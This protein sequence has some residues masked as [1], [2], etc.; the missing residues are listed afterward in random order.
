MM[1]GSSAQIED[2]CPPFSGDLMAFNSNE[3][4]ARTDVTLLL[5]GD[6]QKAASQAACRNSLSLGHV[7][8]TGCGRPQ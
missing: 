7:H 6:Q 8:S 1:V 4:I 3:A 5:I 2:E